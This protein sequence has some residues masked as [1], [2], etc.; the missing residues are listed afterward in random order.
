MHDARCTDIVGIGIGTPGLVDMDKGIV[1]ESPNIPHWHN[2]PLAEIY[3]KKFGIKTYLENDAN[4]AA[5]GEWW[6]GAGKGTKHLICLTLGTGI[7]GGII[8]DGK[9]YHGRDGYAGELGHISLSFDGPKCGCG[10][11][12]CL[13]AYASALGIV[14]STKE[15]IKKNKKSLI[16]KLIDGNLDKITPAIVTRAARKGDK[17][18]KKIWS[19]TG[20]YLGSGIATIVN[21]FNPE[22]VVLTG[23]MTGAGN[24]LLKKMWE[25]VRKRTYK[26]PVKGLKILIGKLP[27]NA[28]AMGAAKTAFQRAEP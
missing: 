10:N 22:M 16:Y 25:T 1:Y 7:G 18:A 8:I 13:E 23:G 3:A 26:C 14:R 21:I 4:S 9:V 27:D 12:G 19:D 11:K 20:Y 17:L 2:I 28:G 6:M 5:L 24:L 15:L